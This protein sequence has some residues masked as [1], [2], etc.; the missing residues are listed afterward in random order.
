[1]PAREIITYL[2]MSGREAVPVTYDNKILTKT[3]Y[4]VIFLY[5]KPTLKLRPIDENG[6]PYT[7]ADFNTF[8]A[9]EIGIDDDFDRTSPPGVYQHSDTTTFT[10]QEVTVDSV[11]YVEISVPLNGATEELEAIIGTSEEITTNVV[12]ELCAYD[13]P[14]DLPTSCSPVPFYIRWKTSV[15]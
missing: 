13:D 6:T 9:Y 2:R 12:A 4:P 14:E 7:L 15:G 11:T 8:N 1:M 10:I 3:K 5:E